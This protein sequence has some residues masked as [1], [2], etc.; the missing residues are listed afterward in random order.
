MSTTY[1]FNEK[2]KQK[3]NKDLFSNRLMTILS[4]T[5]ISSPYTTA[6]I[7]AD[8]VYNQIH[9]LSGKTNFVA[10]LIK[11]KTHQEVIDIDSFFAEYQLSA[12]QKKE[13]HNLI[14][15]ALTN[16]LNEYMMFQY[17]TH[18]LPLMSFLKR[19]LLATRPGTNV[20]QWQFIAEKCFVKQHMKQKIKTAFEGIT[21]YKQIDDKLCTQ[22]V[23]ALIR[24]MTGK[25]FDNIISQ[26]GKGW[27]PDGL[28]ELPDKG[29]NVSP[30]HLFLIAYSFKMNLKKYDE[31]ILRN[32][33]VYDCCC[34]EEN[35]F[36][37]LL[38]YITNINEFYEF[39]G[40]IGENIG[41]FQKSK[42]R[43]HTNE[44]IQK[45]INNFFLTKKGTVTELY[46]PFIRLLESLG[47]VSAEV[48]KAEL[49]EKRKEIAS[50]EIR[51]LIRDVSL[52][53]L[54]MY[55]SLLNNTVDDIIEMQYKNTTERDIAMK[56]I[57]NNYEQFCEKTGSKVKTL[58]MICD[59]FAPESSSYIRA[60]IRPI[61]KSRFTTGHIRKISNGTTTVTRTD[62]LKIGYL[63][64]FIDFVNEKNQKFRNKDEMTKSISKLTGIFEENTNKMLKECCF[65][66]VHVT[67]PLDGLI[68][69]ALS[70]GTNDRCIPEVFQACLPIATEF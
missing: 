5:E 64:T 30:Q 48:R 3:M 12:N 35:M 38:T 53:N 31:M 14:Q 49:D 37:F 52:D 8:N 69:I 51:K 19:E 2:M 59:R 26:K 22:L 63:R 68:C 43:Q 15:L 65:I 58:S 9:I 55:Y 21:N 39:I 6:H 33:N 61:L 28:E 45:E 47:V 10:G 50:K 7:F 60:S 41:K 46:Q 25:R 67:F 17:I 16:E 29:Y 44:Y 66:P 34:Y 24:S 62:I 27:Y 18:N 32:E 40:Y 23:S 20:Q 1:I 42:N 11:G 13:I 57:K 4:E 56:V 54:T 70:S 36:R